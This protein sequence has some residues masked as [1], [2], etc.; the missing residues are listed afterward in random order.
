[1]IAIIGAMDIE[2]SG[3][4]NRLTDTKKVKAVGFEFIRGVFENKDVVICQC[5]VGKVS[6]AAA[7]SALIQ[8]FNPELVLNT[9][10]AGGALPLKQGDIVIA[11]RVVQHDFDVTP[12]GLPKGQIPG[13]DSPYM[14]CDEQ[15]VRKLKKAADAVGYKSVEGVIATGD[16]FISS[17]EKATEITKEFDAYA[18]DMETGAIAQVC[19]IC[20]VKFAALRAVS[21]NGDEVAV[22]SFYEF[23]TEAAGRSIDILTEFVKNY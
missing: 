4:V 2:I 17:K 15:I 22:K 9:G 21:D 5:G 10:V 19:E 1:M 13:F 3:I 20:G 7:V 18:Y 23:V 8:L 6:A 14:K 11:D 12:D 16:C